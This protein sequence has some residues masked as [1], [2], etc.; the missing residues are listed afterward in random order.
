MPP[1]PSRWQVQP[2]SSTCAHSDVML[3]RWLTASESYHCRVSF[4]ARLLRSPTGPGSIWLRQSVLW[5]PFHFSF[6]LQTQQQPQPEALSTLFSWTRAFFKAFRFG[7]R[8]TWET[9]SDFSGSRFHTCRSQLS[10]KQT[11]KHCNNTFMLTIQRCVSGAEG[12]SPYFWICFWPK[13]L[14]VLGSL[15][16]M[17]KSR[18]TWVDLKGKQTQAGNS[19]N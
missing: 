17:Y 5:C 1:T 6:T 7:T 14:N 9:R 3:G 11:K 19:I 2:S 16:N 8:M 13:V 4:L 18:Q 15:Q 10:Q 12:L